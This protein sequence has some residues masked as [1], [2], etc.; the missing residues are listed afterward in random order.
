[1]ADEI[2][3]TVTLDVQD[4]LTP[5][6]NQAAESSA[7]A[8]ARIASFGQ[9]LAAIGTVAAGISGAVGRMVEGFATL[10]NEVQSNAERLGVGVDWLQEWQ[11]A[12][13]QFSADNGALVSGLKELSL[14]AEEFLATGGG[15]AAESFKRLGI[16]A[17]D[18][19]ATAGD[20]EKLL[21]LVVSR[22][23]RIEA[24]A[25][26][27]V[28]GELFGS[29][30]EQLVSLLRQS[31]DELD[32][33][34]QAGRDNG[35][36]ISDEDVEQSRL[37]IQQM[38]QLTTTLQ[39]IKNT[40]LG[41]LLPTINQWL[42]SLNELSQANRQ[43]ISQQ[44]VQGL[45]QL[46]AGIQALASAF[47]WAA[48]MAGGFVPLITLIAELMAGR[49]VFSLASGAMTLLQFASALGEMASRWIPL[50]IDGIRALS[51]ALLTTPIG[52]IVLGITALAG[53][54]YL[55]YSNWGAIAEWFA[56]LW[57]HIRAF[58]GQGIGAIQQ[59]LLAFSPAAQ[60]LKAVDEV[61]ELFT[62]RSLSQL[63][64]DWIGGL[65]SGIGER[66]EQ[67]TSWLRQKI[68]ELTLLMPDW[69]VKRLGLQRPDEPEAA[70]STLSGLGQPLLGNRQSPLLAPRYT[71][72]GGELRIRIDADGNPRV[73][74]MKANG[75]LGYSLDSGLLGVM[76]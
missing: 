46:A 18:L 56:G 62:G 25:A 27:R 7:S 49:F 28:I 17:E 41:A 38:N 71:D 68:G 16:G 23:G 10:G 42:G 73:S 20:T 61:I 43:A 39:S 64:R 52:W 51:V 54:V 44:I 4:R 33:L 59:G 40:V 13:R 47:T 53:A 67:L 12:A 55:I 32:R 9:R 24:S 63:G 8:F 65:A 31:G 72:V 26:P 6:L 69:V 5:A 35:A 66:F 48:G 57:A 29:D 75:G 1:M 30:G 76:A 15:S 60:L 22:L 50:A 45:Q 14:Q 21:E 74:S 2:R 58:F 37:Y 70:A 36:I 34:R 19:Q 11:Y 3:V